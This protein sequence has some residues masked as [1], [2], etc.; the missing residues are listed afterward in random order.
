MASE[1]T[2]ICNTDLLQSA[3]FIFTIPRLNEVQFFCQAINLPGVNSQSTVQITPF[4]DMGVP[5][6]KME[7]EDLN[8]EFLL[9]EELR[10]WSSIY[11]WIK[12]YTQSEAWEDY[13]NLNKLSKYSQ[14]EYINT[15]QYAD[16]I[17]STLSSA[18]NKPKVNIHFIDL[19]PVYLSAIPFDIRVSSAKTMT[20]T[21][22]FRFKRYE[23]TL[24][25]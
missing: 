6:D 25:Q 8:I 3:K 13:T 15:P 11:Y 12:G 4:R 7:Y 19:F 9:D 21:A 22:T 5:G 17:L 18:S 24:L 2:N 1:D 20:A 16:A 10:S 14:Y 23:I